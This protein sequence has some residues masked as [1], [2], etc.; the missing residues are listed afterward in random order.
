MK[1]LNAAHGVVFL[2][3]TFSHI[4]SFFRP[5]QGDGEEAV[6]R[7]E[8]YV[9]DLLRDLLRYFVKLKFF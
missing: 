6:T 2:S 1:H 7:I 4:A 3:R 9:Q 5:V 8:G